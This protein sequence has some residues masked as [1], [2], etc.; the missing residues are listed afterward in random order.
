MKGNLW[1]IA[2][3]FIGLIV[4]LPAAGVAFADNARTATANETTAVDYD[5]NYTL[6][7]TDVEEY[8]NLT[9]TAN[10]TTLDNGT[11]YAFDPPNATIDWINTTATSDGDA[12]AVNYTYAY[13]NTATQTAA[14]LLT[15]AGAWLGFAA[16]IAV[17]GYILMMIPGGSGG[18]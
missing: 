6:G 11:D 13:Y 4:L 18:W 3:L 1:A 17:L 16:I 5:S 14:S 9:V 7:E 12:A 10:N 2:V 15:T 8:T